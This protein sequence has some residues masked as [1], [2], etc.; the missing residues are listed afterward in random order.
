MIA[1]GT[2]LGA[3]QVAFPGAPVIGQ[4]A[5]GGQ[6][7]KLGKLDGWW[8]SPASTG[9]VTQKVNGH[10]AFLGPAFYTPRV[11]QMQARIDGFGAADSMAT[12][13][14]IMEAIS[15]DALSEVAVT[16][17]AGTLYA[18]VRQE[19]DPLLARSGNRVTVSLSVLAPDPRRYGPWQQASTGL[20]IASGGFSLPVTLPIVMTGTGA[21]GALALV[22]DG[23]VDAPL[24]LTVS[25][26]CPP[27]AISDQDGRQLVYSGEALAAGRTL[28]I[29]T[30][31]RTALLDGVANRVVTGSWPLLRPGLNTIQFTASAYDAG[32]L[33]TVSYRSARR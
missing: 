16:D 3:V 4:V 6:H 7:V 30:E 33:L 26:P 27:F 14:Q 25:G 8:D 9:T 31:N 21:A 23:D 17:E 11:V 2:P 13:R 22:N 5:E 20:P 24:L 32:A 10:G 12:A 15:L 18:N 1:P 29:D 28:V 19:G